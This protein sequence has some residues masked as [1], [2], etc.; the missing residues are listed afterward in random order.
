MV[1]H[2]RTSLVSISFQ[3][4]KP[5][6]RI[7]WVGI[8]SE[9][10]P[11]CYAPRCL[12][13]GNDGSIPNRLQWI[14]S[15]PALTGL[16]TTL[17]PAATPGPVLQHMWRLKLGDIPVVVAMTP[18]G[19]PWARFWVTS[20]EALASEIDTRLWLHLRIPAH[21]IRP[22]HRCA[23]AGG[24][25][26]F[27]GAGAGQRGGALGGPLE[28]TTAGGDGAGYGQRALRC[29]AGGESGAGAALGLKGRVA[30]RPAGGGGRS[31][32]GRGGWVAAIERHAG[33]CLPH[34][35]PYATRRR[36]PSSSWPGQGACTTPTVRPARRWTAG[37]T[38]RWLP[39]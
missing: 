10:S 39:A 9:Q 35:L 11:G 25:R 13:S 36:A 12:G 30:E 21:N 37:G 28:P 3:L 17:P 27:L 34:L 4:F 22:V 31:V 23:A 15:R 18:A 6:E 20:Q 5:V 19:G 14:S 1:L 29:P 2:Y 16:L 26:V 7:P 24:A 32:P 33:G 8:A 38:G